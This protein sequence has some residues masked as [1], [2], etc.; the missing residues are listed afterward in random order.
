MPMTGGPCWRMRCP[1][2]PHPTCP[3]PR[4]APRQ[5]SDRCRSGSQLTAGS[6][7]GGDRP[8]RACGGPAARPHRAGCAGCASRNRV[9]RRASTASLPGMDGMESV[10]WKDT[11]LGATERSSRRSSLPYLLLLGDFDQVR[12]AAAGAGS[13]LGG[14]ARLPLGGGLPGLC[15]QGVC[16]EAA[17]PRPRSD[18]ARCSSPRMMGRPPPRGLRGA[19]RLPSLE[20]LQPAEELGSL[21]AESLAELGEPLDWSAKS[22]SR[23]VASPQPLGGRVDMRR[24]VKARR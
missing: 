7:L 1:W 8:G 24:V 12:R 3:G 23:Q 21:S 15:G 4:S 11:V 13:R 5:G 18:A 14:Q 6:A 9:H 16:A 19:M 10:R 20:S 17:R 2:T 22:S